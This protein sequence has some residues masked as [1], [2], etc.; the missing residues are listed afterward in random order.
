MV[1]ISIF[2][3]NCLIAHEFCPKVQLPMKGK[4][5]LIVLRKDNTYYRRMFDMK[6]EGK[7]ISVTGG[8]GKE[9]RYFYKMSKNAEICRFFNKIK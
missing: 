7:V 2:Y 5:A 3:L 8:G 9:N 6:V 4:R 1:Y